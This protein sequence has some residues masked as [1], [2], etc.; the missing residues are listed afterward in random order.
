MTLLER[1]VEAITEGAPHFTDG[2]LRAT[3]VAESRT[4]VIAER[5][6]TRGR[7]AFGPSD[8]YRA[9]NVPTW[10]TPAMRRWI[11]QARA[12]DIPAYLRAMG[13]RVL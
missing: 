3:Y 4:V 5:V 13:A 1:I 9:D 7:W 6:G 10:L 8:I 2:R 12:A 11:H